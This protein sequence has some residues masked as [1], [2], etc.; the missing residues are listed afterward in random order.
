MKAWEKLL[1]LDRT[2]GFNR[3]MVVEICKT[4]SKCP[5]AIESKHHLIG[6]KRLEK[7]CNLG[8]SVECVN[9]YMDIKVN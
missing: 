5:A 9:C 3:E 2:I 1:S 8:C 6:D 4:Q 7:F